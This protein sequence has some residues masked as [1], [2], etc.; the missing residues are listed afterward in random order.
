MEKEGKKITIGSCIHFTELK[1][2]TSSSF[3]SLRGSNY[4][5][6]I[7]E[8]NKNLPL[9]WKPN[10]TKVSLIFQGVRDTGKLS[11]FKGGYWDKCLCSLPSILK[12]FSLLHCLR[13]GDVWQSFKHT[14]VY[15]T[16]TSST[17]YWHLGLAAASFTVKLCPQLITIVNVDLLSPALYLHIT[18]YLFHLAFKHF[19]ARLVF[20]YVW[21][22]GMCVWCFFFFKL[23]Q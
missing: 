2:K 16:Q 7:A 3:L 14:L 13:S 9:H 12:G 4:S 5:F 11:M 17:L 21:G 15:S 1:T 20:L 19:E 10:I 8:S 6:S 22:G 23:A 18:F